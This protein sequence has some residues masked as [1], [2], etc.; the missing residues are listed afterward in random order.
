MAWGF[1]DEQ[2][3]EL[4][5]TALAFEYWLL[6]RTINGLYTLQTHNRK[7]CGVGVEGGWETVESI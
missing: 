7:Y 5:S 1:I 3:R 4:Q 6:L 2:R